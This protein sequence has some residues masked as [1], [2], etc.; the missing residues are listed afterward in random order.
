[1][2][3]QAHVPA[4]QAHAAPEHLDDLRSFANTDVHQPH[5]AHA[6]GVPAGDEATRPDDYV[7]RR[8]RPIHVR[9]KPYGETLLP[10]DVEIATGVLRQQ[11]IERRRVPHVDDAER[12]MVCDAQVQLAFTRRQID[13]VQPSLSV[14]QE[15][16]QLGVEIDPRPRKVAEAASEVVGTGIVQQ[17]RSALQQ[18]GKHRSHGVA[19]GQHPAEKREDADDVGPGRPIRRARTRYRLAEKYPQR[20]RRVELPPLRRPTAP[21]AAL[22]VE[23]Q[24]AAEQVHVA[25]LV[26][27]ACGR[28]EMA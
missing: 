22:L 20:L 9:E 2:P 25:V 8:V 7:H 24:Q 19:T 13:D 21:D 17:S 23:G 3:L 4:L 16:A 26:L 12:R 6:P 5:C 15:I 10:V 27:R 28:L 1:M 14:K 18:P 11:P